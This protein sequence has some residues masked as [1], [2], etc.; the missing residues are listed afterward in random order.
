LPKTDHRDA[1]FDDEGN[2]LED[3]PADPMEVA[4]RK[5]NSEARNRFED[6]IQK[7]KHSNEGLDFLSSSLSNLETT[8]SR[9]WFLVLALVNK[10]NMNL[11]L[12]QKFLMKLSYTHLMKSR[13]RGDTKES[14]KHKEIDKG[15]STRVCSIC[16]Q[17]VQHDARNCPNKSV[18]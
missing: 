7:A 11:S 15:K 18:L 12:V 4:I 14:R 9:R 13:Q 5:K 3:V 8:F 1:F 6:L 2:L 16:K 17:T 10:M